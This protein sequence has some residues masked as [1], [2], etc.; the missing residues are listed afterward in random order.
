M[1]EMSNN[2]MNVIRERLADI[3][4]Q[5][6]SHWMRYLFQICPRNADGSVTIPRDKVQRWTRQLET[7]Y[8]L[9]PEN[10]QESDKHQADR[11]VKALYHPS[12]LKAVEH[13]VEQVLT[14][15]SEV[16]DSQEENVTREE[17]EKAAALIIYNHL[18]DP[19]GIAWVNGADV[20]LAV[21]SLNVSEEEI[22]QADD[23]RMMH[24]ALIEGCE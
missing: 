9:L 14:Y 15:K 13:L 23:L 10:E 20:G 19:S 21:E 4:H 7:A 1:P 12:L 5:I 16:W 24:E 22:K 2:L 11:V 8:L 17:A 18:F 6:W 3:Q